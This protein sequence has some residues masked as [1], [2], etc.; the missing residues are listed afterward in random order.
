MKR[1]KS[2]W[3]D[4]T[5]I[6][7]DGASLQSQIPQLFF[8]TLQGEFLVISKCFSAFLRATIILEISWEKRNMINYFHYGQIEVI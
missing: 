1:E 6:K 8:N 2:F 7:S 5:K 3:L 4:Y